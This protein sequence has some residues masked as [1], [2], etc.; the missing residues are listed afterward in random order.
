MLLDDGFLQE[1]SHFKTH[2]EQ[3]ALLFFLCKP[4]LEGRREHVGEEFEGDWK[5][6]FHEGY[7]DKD[8]E[9]DQS[10]QVS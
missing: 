2:L 10:Q 4:V 6:E 9:R 3:F 1:F 5:E 7:D 8:R